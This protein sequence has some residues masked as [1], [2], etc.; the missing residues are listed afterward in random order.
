M[1]APAV[2]GRGARVKGLAR[3]RSPACKALGTFPPVKRI[4]LRVALALVAL[5]AAAVA[6]EL[7]VERLDVFGVNYYPDVQRYL[8]DAIEQAPPG[9]VSP[10][11]RIFENRTGVWLELTH[12]EYMTDERRLR[13]GAEHVPVT[14][15]MPVLFLGDSVTLAWGVDDEE[16]WP[17]LIER[18]ARAPDGRPLDCMNAGH[19][20]YDATQQASLLRGWGPALHPELVIL[21][22]NFNDV[23]PTWDQLVELHVAQ[24][25]AAEGETALGRF[26]WALKALARYRSDLQRLA[27]EDR[28]TI[29]PYSYYPSGWPRCEKALEDV[30]RTCAELGARL[31]V[32]DHT[33]PVIPELARWCE[34]RGVARIATALSEEDQRRYRNSPI[35]THLNAEGNAIV[36]RE[37]VEQLVGLGV[38]VR[39]G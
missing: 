15:G 9:E 11:G 1:L 37:A 8:R 21:T 2:T 27:H 28:S 4:L 31:V 12:F 18:A 25:G 13:S 10:E 26:F 29:P 35:D 7:L 5:A 16:S 38:L 17:R 20:M 39:G 33:S 34:E 23:H 3:F 32:N 36:A 22:F 14:G 24:P 6:A 30:R 19:L